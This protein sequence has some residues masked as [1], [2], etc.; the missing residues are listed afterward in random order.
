MTWITVV[1]AASWIG[2][3]LIC[4]V[5]GLLI[6]LTGYEYGREKG[7][8]SGYRIG[9]ADYQCGFTRDREGR[10]I[11][12]DP[13]RSGLPERLPRGDFHRSD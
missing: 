4:V 6:W 10:H 5:I 2:V 11:P 13:S 12:A 1:A 7:F 9:A 3:A 8:D